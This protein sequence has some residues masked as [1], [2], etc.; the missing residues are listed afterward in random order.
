[1]SIKKKRFFKMLFVE[2]KWLYNDML[3]SGDIF[4]YD[5]KTKITNSLD[6]N[7]QPVQHELTNLSSQM[8]QSLV[9]RTKDYVK[10]LSKKKAKGGSIGKLKFKS[11]V[12]SIPLKQ[13]GN[14]YKVLNENY[15]K[16]QGLNKKFKVHG[17][18]QIP[19][20]AEFANA[21]LVKRFDDYYL[22]VTV[23]EQKESQ[24]LVGEVGLDFGI[25]NS[26]TTSDGEVYN[27]NFEETKGVKKAQKSL[28]KKRKGSA[29]RR[30]QKDIIAK[31]HGKLNNI[32][33][34]AK[35]KFVSNLKDKK[36]IAVQDEQLSKWHKDKQ[37]SRKVQHD[38]MGGIISGLKKM[39]QTIVVGKYEPTTKKCFVC[40]EVADM[41]L[42]KRTFKCLECG[43]T[44]D[45][46]VKSAIHI[47]LLGKK[48][49]LG[50]RNILPVEY[51]SSAPGRK[52]RSK[53]YMLKQEATTFWDNF[54]KLKRSM[55]GSWLTP[56]ATML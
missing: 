35:N 4:N 20:D 12:F 14:T 52:A 39:S 44:M 9:N 27:Y 37:L 10:A 34:D 2:A 11:S 5:D 47:L 8:K 48:V 23:Y 40:D 1:M 17:L 21:T 25:K 32:K 22:Y 42:K 45:R 29:N 28:S 36:L 3:S 56:E 18:S 51:K 19:L 41:T 53:V 26:I 38:I 13:F 54:S 49:S 50:Q 31:R 46:D 33:K 55:D 16:I 43:F 30:K 7:K 6:K 24:V 15:V